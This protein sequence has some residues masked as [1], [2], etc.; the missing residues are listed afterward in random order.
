MQKTDNLEKGNSNKFLN[1]Q[2]EELKAK[3]ELEIKR[4]QRG[5][6]NCAK[7]ADKLNTSNISRIPPSSAGASI[8]EQKPSYLERP[9]KTQMCP[10]LADNSGY[11]PGKPKKKTDLLPRPFIPMKL[12]CTDP[13]CPYAHNPIELDLV[14]NDVMANNLSKQIKKKI[15]VDVDLNKATKPV[16]LM[17]GL[18]TTGNQ[19]T[20][21]AGLLT[22]VVT[23][24]MKNLTSSPKK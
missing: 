17:K 9:K 8:V 12:R 2:I 11:K 1:I 6:V 4:K 18:V 21:S 3:I 24:G 14:P 23:T 5:I 7:T 22:G 10:K 16:S 19:A 15:Q 20:K 13:N